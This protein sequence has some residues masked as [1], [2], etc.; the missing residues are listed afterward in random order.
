MNGEFNE[1]PLASFL[2]LSGGLFLESSD[3]SS[4]GGWSKNETIK[5]EPLSNSIGNLFIESTYIGWVS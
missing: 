1:S 3:D 2:S 5:F 4:N